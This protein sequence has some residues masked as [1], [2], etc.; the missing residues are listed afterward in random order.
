VADTLNV[1]RLERLADGAPE[2]MTELIS[3]FIEESGETVVA[4]TQAVAGLDRPDLT[5][6]AH[7]LGGSCAVIGAAPL[8]GRLL[9]LESGAA[10]ASPTELASL[11]E[12]IARDLDATV[13]F[14]KAYVE[15]SDK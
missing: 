4:M 9:D 10:N 8:A 3:L 12:A 1:A 14:L 7:R 6:L 5:R 11:M 15:G 13:R 2:L